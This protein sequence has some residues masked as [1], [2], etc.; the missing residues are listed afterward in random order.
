MPLE[1]LLA[2]Y[3]YADNPQAAG[4]SHTSSSP[5]PTAPVPL[6]H[7]L[8]TQTAGN[9]NFLT[10]DSTQQTG[11]VQAGSIDKG[12]NVA[13]LHGKP[14]TPTPGVSEQPP[15]A[16]PGVLGGSPLASTKVTENGTFGREA[17][18]KPEEQAEQATAA[19]MDVF[20]H[21]QALAERRASGSQ[22][23]PSALNPPAPGKEC[24]CHIP[25]A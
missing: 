5:R 17:H 12:K 23:G 8:P 1:Q 14:S 25:L 18:V 10:I 21:S 7:P 4:P 15:S 6:N 20:E 9:S 3:R 11:Q 13:T 24:L 16:A 2:R 22:A 19:G